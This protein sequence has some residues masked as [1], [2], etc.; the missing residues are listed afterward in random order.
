[1]VAAVENQECRIG[2]F[3]TGA[4]N[5]ARRADGLIE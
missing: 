2:V 3:S 5:A 4:P 1:M